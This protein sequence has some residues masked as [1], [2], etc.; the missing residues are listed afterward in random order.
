VN[1]VNV[2]TS[3]NLTPTLSIDP[4]LQMLSRVLFKCACLIRNS[5]MLVCAFAEQVRVVAEVVVE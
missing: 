5:P 3:L 1:K 4:K 2:Q